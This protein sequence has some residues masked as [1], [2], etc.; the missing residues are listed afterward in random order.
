[1]ERDRSVR[2]IGNRIVPDGQAR[3]GAGRADGGNVS[4]TRTVANVA[5]HE[6]IKHHTGRNRA[7]VGPDVQTIGIVFEIPLGVLVG[8]T[9]SACKKSPLE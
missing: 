4:E 7:G 6:L 2:S 8:G 1:M 9:A 5:D 3:E